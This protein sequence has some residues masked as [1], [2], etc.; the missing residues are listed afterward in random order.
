MAEDLG[1][2]F[3]AIDE[4]YEMSIQYKDTWKNFQK[5]G[6]FR[7]ERLW[8]NFTFFINWMEENFSREKIFKVMN[9]SY[10]LDDSLLLRV[11]KSEKNNWASDDK[12]TIFETWIMSNLYRYVEN[13]AK[14]TNPLKKIVGK[15]KFTKMIEEWHQDEYSSWEP[16]KNYE[17]RKK[18][19]D[20]RIEICNEDGS[21][22]RYEKEYGWKDYWETEEFQQS[23]TKQSLS[24][25]KLSEF[26][27][28][29]KKWK[30]LVNKKIVP[31]WYLFDP[32]DPNRPQSGHNMLK[33]SDPQLFDF[34]K[35]QKWYHRISN[36]SK[37]HLEEK[38]NFIIDCDQLLGIGG[39]GIVIRKSVKT[40]IGAEEDRQE[41]DRYEALKIVPIMNASK[42]SKVSFDDNR[43]ND[44]KHNS[45]I[46]TLNVYLD[47]FQSFDKRV[48]AIVIGKENFECTLI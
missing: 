45:M 32:K 30:E 1:K 9:K 48:F 38:S 19:D 46:E 6:K 42:N 36:N 41:K 20:I 34:L 3:K 26:L 44:L 22:R 29:N 13:P 11:W 27:V 37:Y 25:S 10:D 39:E 4:N 43:L 5:T 18:V 16:S 35:K 33:S 8:K 21:P 12:S 15:I 24:G 2:I 14:K 40:K 17:N 31:S 7:D 23:F 47:Y 28:F